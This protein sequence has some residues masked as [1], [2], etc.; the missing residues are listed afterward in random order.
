MSND[1]KINIISFLPHGILTCES[2][3]F[4]CRRLGLQVLHASLMQGEGERNSGC[5]GEARKAKVKDVKIGRH[6]RNSQVELEYGK[7]R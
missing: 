4:L 7:E 1:L 2:N 3:T 5:Q 6:G